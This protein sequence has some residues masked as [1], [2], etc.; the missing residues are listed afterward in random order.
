MVGDEDPTARQLR[1][2][3]TLAD[4][5]HF[6]HAATRLHLTQP[7]LSQQ[8]RSLENRLGVQLFE[9]S[10]RRVEL[11]AEGRTLLPFARKVVDAM[12]GLRNA[13]HRSTLS[14]EEL[15]FGLSE[16][17]TVLA[18]T[19]SALSMLRELHPTL[20]ISIKVVDFVERTTMLEK[21]EIDAAF[22]YLPVSGDMC[23]QPL[24][25]EPRVVCVSSSDPLADRHSVRLHE[26]ASHPVVGLTPEISQAERNFWAVDPR[27]DGS[28]V[29]YTT[30][31]VTKCE[32]LLSAVSFDRA[33]AFVPAVTAELYPRPNIRYLPVQDVPP[34]TFGLA[35]PASARE[36]PQ[37]AMLEDMCHRLRQ[38]GVPTG[39]I[40]SPGVPQHVVRRN[41]RRGQRTAGSPRV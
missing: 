33:I 2:L 39:T 41:V 17:V 31:Q 20:N 21:G 12:T 16:N 30:H 14:S 27:L 9:R 37:I 13:A 24:T 4:E 28:A 23:S 19:N 38:R 3:L 7:A 11:T 25:T 40:Q 5:L 35:W 32:A 8:I 36:K 10:S 34:C 26:L 22:V 6:G 1:L 29:S 15:T 18:A